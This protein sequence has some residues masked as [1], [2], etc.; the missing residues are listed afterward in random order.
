MTYIVRLKEKISYELLFK[1]L[2][3]VE[4]ITR[5]RVSKNEERKKL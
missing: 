3:S 4:G 2:G 5:V 1:E